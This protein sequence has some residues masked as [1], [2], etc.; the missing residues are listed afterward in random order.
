[1]PAAQPAE[2]R[3]HLWQHTPIRSRLHDQHVER[4]RVAGRGGVDDRAA[5]TP[6]APEQGLGAS[7]A[8][9]GLD[10]RRAAQTTVP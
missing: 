1:M 2:L 9:D 3:T 4:N 10:S 5:G 7:R 6:A 8:R